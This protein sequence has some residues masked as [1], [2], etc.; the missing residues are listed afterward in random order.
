MGKKTLYHPVSLHVIRGSAEYCGFR[1]GK[2]TQGYVFP[3]DA[4]AT[5][6]AEIVE[7]PPE[8]SALPM[9]RQLALL[10][11]CFMDDI[12]VMGIWR[13]S[14]NVLMCALDVQLNRQPDPDQAAA[15]K[16]YEGIEQ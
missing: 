11:E 6:H 1:F 7:L 2:I 5:Y 3:D 13:S 16:E 8:A 15:D 9:W 12:I 14:K 10:T 4:R